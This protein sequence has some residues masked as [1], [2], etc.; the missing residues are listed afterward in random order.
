M[1]RLIGIALGMVFAA[2]TALGNGLGLCEIFEEPMGQIASNCDMSMK[3]YSTTHTVEWST[4]GLRPDRH[5]LMAE[6]GFGIDLEFDLDADIRGSSVVAVI[7]PTREALD[8]SGKPRAVD[9]SSEWLQVLV[10]VDDSGTALALRHYAER[11]AG[12]ELIGSAAG[13]ELQSEQPRQRLWLSVEREAGVVR[14]LVDTAEAAAASPLQIELD[15]FGELLPWVQL[16]GASAPNAGAV[17]NSRYS[18]PW[19]WS[20]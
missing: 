10:I 1:K 14:L 2:G 9:S 4:L 16:R 12:I 3:R 18:N 17:S 7:R 20:R 19:G 15:G 8:A 5:G 11:A 13:P 6:A